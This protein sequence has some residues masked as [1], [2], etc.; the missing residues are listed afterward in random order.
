[1][2][3]QVRFN[4][5][6]L[7]LSEGYAQTMAGS[8]LPYIAARRT[9]AVIS[10]DGGRPL[11]TSRFDA[12]APRATAVIVHGF[13][14]NVDKFSE[15]IHSLLRNGFSVLAYDQRGH[16]R[17]WR[18]EGVG[19]IS[20]TH[21]DR[22]DEYVRDLER[23]CAQALSAMPKPWVLFAHSMGG[24]VSAL[25]LETHPGVFARAA[26]CAPMI[27]PDRGGIPLAAGRLLCRAE[28]ALGKGKKRVF[29]SKPYAGA[30]AFETSCATGRARFE[31]YEA[32]R[33][34]THEFQNNGP[35]YGW[36]LES[37]NVT[38][39]ILAPGAVEKIDV[40][41]RVY[42]AEND[43]TVR[44]DAQARFAARLARGGRT[45]VKGAKHEIYRSDDAVLFPWWRGVLRFLEGGE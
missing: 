18:A 42:T 10:G 9:D 1:M 41:V 28:K 27:A 15:P 38:D 44:P 32:L 5:D 26:L 25:F 7:V 34:A 14:E 2:T 43:G 30:E 11:F 39:R 33:V 37:L 36:T 45:V 29:F 22:F 4:A 20:L 40:P 6:G 12:D 19:D 31:W 13:T 16:G 3:N 8:V 21:V 24:A 35:S 23:V 17:S